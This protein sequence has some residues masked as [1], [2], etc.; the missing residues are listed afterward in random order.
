MRQWIVKQPYNQTHEVEAYRS[1]D[2]GLIHVLQ[3]DRLCIMCSNLCLA[4]VDFWHHNG[5]V[6]GKIATFREL[7]RLHD[8]KGDTRNDCFPYKAIE[9]DLLKGWIDEEGQR[10]KWAEYLDIMA[11]DPIA[12]A[13]F[14]SGKFTSPI[15]F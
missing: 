15:P 2:D 9:W 10:I 8:K 5:R 11:E 7:E 6:S 14:P 1:P 12:I 13:L 3:Y 4:D